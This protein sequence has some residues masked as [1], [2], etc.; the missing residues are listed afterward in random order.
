[1]NIVGHMKDMAF[2]TS[3]GS[4]HVGF[5]AFAKR[6]RQQDMGL[7]STDLETAV[8]S[9]SGQER[10]GNGDLGIGYLDGNRVAERQ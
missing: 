9:M 5:P 3:N 1:M 7:Y 4:L 10:Q 8:Q 2:R 6:G